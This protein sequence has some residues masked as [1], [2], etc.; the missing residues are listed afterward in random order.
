VS[1]KRRNSRGLHYNYFRDFDPAVGRYVESDL[2]G[3]G[4]GINT[5]AY[6]SGE[7]LTRRDAT[8]LAPGDSVS[9]PQ[10]AA[11]DVTV[12]PRFQLPTFPLAKINPNSMSV[13]RARPRHMTMLPGG[14]S[15]FRAR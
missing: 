9:S 15:V 5:Y 6:V 3:L 7:P 12:W 1:A 11:I 2:I 13:R 4:G 14:G 10:A 8:G